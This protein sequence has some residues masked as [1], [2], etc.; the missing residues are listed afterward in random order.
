[1]RLLLLLI[2]LL[3]L[4][5]CAGDIKEVGREPSMSPVGTGLLGGRCADADVHLRRGCAQY[6]GGHLGR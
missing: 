6:P 5:G 3:P 2:A 1:M 4:A